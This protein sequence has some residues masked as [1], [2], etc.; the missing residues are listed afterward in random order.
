MNKEEIVKAIEDI[1]AERTKSVQADVEYWKGLT[2]KWKGIAANNQQQLLEVQSQ[3]ESK[4]DSILDVVVKSKFSFLIF[5]GWTFFSF[6]FG[7]FV[8]S[9]LM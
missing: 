2:N 3:L 1:V 7:W 4:T 5:M 8:H 9:V 6:G